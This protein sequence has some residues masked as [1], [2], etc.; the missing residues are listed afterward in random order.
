MLFGLARHRNSGRNNE[1]I[2]DYEFGAK[3]NKK[4]APKEKI[5]NYKIL[6]L[7][8]D[9]SR[10]SKCRKRKEIYMFVTP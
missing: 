6:W 8:I 5:N 4:K 9:V 3:E 10:V 7:C 2:M 1:K